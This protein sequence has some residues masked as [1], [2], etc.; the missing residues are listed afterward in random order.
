MQKQGWTRVSAIFGNVQQQLKTTS[1]FV[2]QQSSSY[3]HRTFHC[4]SL[5]RYNVSDF[6]PREQLSS[7]YPKLRAGR[8][9]TLLYSGQVFSD[10]ALSD[11]HFHR[12]KT[13]LNDALFL[14]IDKQ[15]REYIHGEMK[16]RREQYPL[17]SIVDLTQCKED[18]V[19]M[20]DNKLEA[21]QKIGRQL[22][23]DEQWD[24]CS[25]MARRVF[26]YLTAEDMRRADP[27]LRRLVTQLKNMGVE[28]VEL[29]PTIC[30][31]YNKKMLISAEKEFLKCNAELYALQAQLP[32]AEFESSVEV[33]KKKAADSAKAEYFAKLLIGDFQFKKA[34]YIMTLASDV[35]DILLDKHSAIFTP[36]ELAILKSDRERRQYELAQLF[37]YVSI[38][39]DEYS[40]VC[41]NH[42]YDEVS[43]TL[44][45]P[46][47]LHKLMLDALLIKVKTDRQLKKSFKKQ[48][49]FYA[50]SASRRLRYLK[51]LNPNLEKSNQ[52][53]KIF[54]HQSARSLIPSRAKNAFLALLLALSLY[55]LYFLWGKWMKQRSI[56]KEVE[57]IQEERRKEIIEIMKKREEE[58]D[59]DD[60]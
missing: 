38:L 54:S 24:Y 37:T 22:S 30:F 59:D 20:L 29:H 8:A 32:R 35:A 15:S 33:N 52:L 58:E 48:A 53:I 51:R 26:I 34:L 55:A 45:N 18:I 41:K 17:V 12:V 42:N 50:F 36:N 49:D 43:Y 7:I 2:L 11:T 47:N 6:D 57:Q 9:F 19:P 4:S 44:D 21:F 5:A 31:L 56:A 39:A 27:L 16:E 60:F 23:I 13:I 1:L 14:G 25:T 3:Q 10:L 40:T 28:S 46:S